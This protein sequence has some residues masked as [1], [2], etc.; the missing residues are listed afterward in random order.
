MK[1]TET[2]EP[3]YR[4]GAI[5]ALTAAILFRRNF[6]AEVSLFTGIE[7]L[8][9]NA[10]DWF[11]LLQANPF[12]GLSFLAV[13][14]LANYFLVGIVFLALSTRLWPV[15]KS[16]VALALTSGLVGVTINLSSNISLTMF[17][18]SQRY[19][20]ATSAVQK[21][22]P[23]V[24]RAVYPGRQR[25]AGS[26]ARHGRAGQSAVGCP[27]WAAFF[28][29][30]AFL[31]PWDGHP[32][33]ARQRLRPGLLSGL[34]ADTHR[35]GLP[36]P[37]RCRIVLDVLAFVGGQGFMEICTGRQDMKLLLCYH[38]RYGSTQQYAEWLHAQVGGELTSIKDLSQHN[39]AE[40]DVLVF[41]GYVHA[42]KISIR[43][44]I[45]KYWPVIKH[46]PVVLFSTSGTP[47][48]ETAPIQAMFEDSFPRDI[49]KNWP[50]FLC[51]GG[52]IQRVGTWRTGSY[53]TW[54]VGSKKIRT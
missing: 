35:P 12:I 23:A 22:G 51:G 8:P 7:A 21:T 37:G 46:K 10:A 47:P 25:P 53:R 29:C 27:G 4:A 34:S 41:G 19:A 15:N 39:L 38:S 44:V 11:I 33:I 3:L 9:T 18:L 20:A 50:I 54:V 17:S 5:A 2:W 13:F 48:T 52:L 40:C 14:D 30:A 49:V 31:P 16:L 36:A 1:A 24:R 43:N 26:H 6:G 42:G 32:R 45:Q 28:V